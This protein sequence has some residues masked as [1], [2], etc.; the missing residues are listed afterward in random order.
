MKFSASVLCAVLGAALCASAQPAVSDVTLSQDVNSCM[1]T[2]EYKLSETAIVTVDFLTNGVSIG[3]ARFN[4]VVGDV[5]KVV[6]VGDGESGTV[7]KIWWRPEKGCRNALLPR[8]LPVAVR[9]TAWATNTPPNYMVIRIDSGTQHLPAAQ[10]T[11]YYET[12][13]ALPFPGGVTN[14]LCKTDYLVFR[15]CPAANVKFRC[16]R[17][18]GECNVAEATPPHYVKLTNDFYI[19]IYEM[20]QRQFEHLNVKIKYKDSGGATQYTNNLSFFTADHRMRPVE[21]IGMHQLRGWV[22]YDGNNT[23]ENGKRKYWPESGHEIMKS[24]GTDATPNALWSVR[25]ITGQAFDLPT[26]AQWEF[27]ARAGKGGVL[28][29]GEILKLGSSADSPETLESTARVARYARCELSMD[30]T[31][32]PENAVATTPPSAGGTA[33]VGSYEPNDWGIYDMTGNVNEMCLD[34]YVLY[35]NTSYFADTSSDCVYVDP[36]GPSTI[37]NKDSNNNGRLRVI[38]GGSWKTGLGTTLV[39]YRNGVWGLSP[40]TDVGFRLCLTLP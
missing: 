12:A 24:D 7:R 15:K 38:R 25:E 20:T 3:G 17:A 34:N 21:N 18:E 16:G 40:N 26:D 19:G 10:R 9:V 13:D 14:D 2:V 28:P 29:D 5:H 32:A 27:A 11:A 8:D 4:N 6:S 37:A 33:I 23:I 22:N 31:V 1:V 35:N 36:V 39:P 30:I